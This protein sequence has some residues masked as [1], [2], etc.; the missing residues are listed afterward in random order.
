MSFFSSLWRI[1]CSCGS[2]KINDTSSYFLY[3]TNYQAC[4]HAV[5]YF[6]E[7][8]T[9]FQRFW[10]HLKRI[11]QR[12]VIRITKSASKSAK[13]PREQERFRKS[14]KVS[15]KSVIPKL[16]IDY[17]E[18]QEKWQESLW[19]IRNLEWIMNPYKLVF[20]KIPHNPRKHDDDL[21]NPER[22]MKNRKRTLETVHQWRIPATLN[23]SSKTQM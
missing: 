14:Q 6:Y 13:I 1:R 12:I 16:L 5:T 7:S 10:K 4:R 8:W 20:Q 15:E 19:T 23:T 3:I 22:Q 18:S 11:I 21:M 17:Q 9:P 2:A